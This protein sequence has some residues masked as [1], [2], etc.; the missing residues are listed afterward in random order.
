[1][2]DR[3]WRGRYEGKREVPF[4][5]R[6]YM[7]YPRLLAATLELSPGYGWA[8][9]SVRSIKVFIAPAGWR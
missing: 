6:G 3:R 2:E 8:K 1:M 5:G 4:Y 9:V 7:R